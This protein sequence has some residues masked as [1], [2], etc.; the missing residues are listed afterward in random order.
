MRHFKALLH[1][2][3]HSSNHGILPSAN[4]VPSSKAP[5]MFDIFRSTRIR[6]CGLAWTFTLALAGFICYSQ[7]IQYLRLSNWI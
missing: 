4:S 7:A 5:L 2:R 6:G 1:Q 3:T